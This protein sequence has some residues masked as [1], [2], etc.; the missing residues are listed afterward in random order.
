MAELVLACFV[1]IGF[2]TATSL[3]LVN[4]LGASLHHKND[5]KYQYRTERSQKLRKEIRKYPNQVY[6]IYLIMAVILAILSNYVEWEWGMI[7]FSA[8]YITWILDNMRS[9]CSRAFE[10]FADDE[11]DLNFKE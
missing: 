6:S 10:A 11:Y 2:I 4:A 8:L 7:C 1:A 5:G 3:V 9:F